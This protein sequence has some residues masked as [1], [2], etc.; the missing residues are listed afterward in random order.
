MRRIAL[1]LDPESNQNLL[2]GILKTSLL[3]DAGFEFDQVSSKYHLGSAQD[4]KHSAEYVIN[5][6]RAEGILYSTDERVNAISSEI[7][8][9]IENLNQSMKVGKEIQAES[10]LSEQR[11]PG[12]K[13]SLLSMQRR[14]VALHTNLPFSADFSVPGAGKTWIGYATYTILKAKGLVNKLLVVGPISSFRPWQEEYV[15][16]FGKEPKS[17][18]IKGTREDRHKAFE[19]YSEKGYF[20]NLVSQCHQ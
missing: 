14:A 13:A 9:Q 5:L 19:A 3:Y 12:F 16:I 2:V 15:T 20:L 10:K 7:R 4:I 17:Q 11:P 1:T 18:E 6:L 8:G